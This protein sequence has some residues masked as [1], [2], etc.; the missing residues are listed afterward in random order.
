MENKKFDYET[1]KKEAT[2]RL[3]LGDSMLGKDGVFAPWFK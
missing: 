3:K 2:E 1:F